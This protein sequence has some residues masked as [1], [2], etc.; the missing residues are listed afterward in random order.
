VRRPTRDDLIAAR[1]RR[2]PDVIGPDL[3]VYS[4]AIGHHFGRPGNRFWLAL[5]AAHLTDRVLSPHEDRELLSYG[6]GVTN[7][8]DGATARADE[9]TAEQ[10]RTGARRLVTKV[11]R[12]RPRV[13]AI[14]GVSA[15]RIAFDEPRAVIGARSDRIGASQVWV[16]PNPSGL[17]AHYQLPDLARCYR[18]MAHY[19][20]D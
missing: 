4:A 12:F 11:R 7:L 2:I 13:V 10:L 1:G 3:A 17:N 14:L 6:L 15:Y 18:E 5:H 8:V 20:N 9:L 19:R 16:L